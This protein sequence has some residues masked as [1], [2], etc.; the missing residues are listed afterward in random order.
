MQTLEARASSTAPWNSC[1][2]TLEIAERRRRMQPLTRPELAVLLAYAKLSLNPSCSTATCR[3]IPIS[4]ANWAAISPKAM[5]EQFPDALEKHRLRREIIATQLANSMINRGGPALR[6]AHRGRDWRCGGT[7]SPWP[8][9][10]C[11]TATAC[12]R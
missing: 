9:P 12:R 8:L 5:A 10:P 6:R 1:R 3:T 11:V 2:T 7:R 4:A